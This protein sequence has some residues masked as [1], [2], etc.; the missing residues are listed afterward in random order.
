MPVSQSPRKKKRIQTK[1]HQNIGSVKIISDA[2]GEAI[3]N[4][5]EN[6]QIS[7]PQAVEGTYTLRATYPRENKGEK[8]VFEHNAG[9]HGVYLNER[10]QLCANFDRLAA[11]DTNG[12][13][14]NGE[15]VF[16]SVFAMTKTTL[17]RTE[18]DVNFDTHAFYFFG[19]PEGINKEMV[20]LDIALVNFILPELEKFPHKLGIVND[21]DLGIHREV[22]AGELPYLGDKILDPRIKLIYAS[23]DAGAQLTNEILKVCDSK[24]KKIAKYLTNNTEN[25][26]RTGVGYAYCKDL[27][28]FDLN[29]IE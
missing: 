10:A 9:A 21:S 17:S 15:E 20:G 26:E 1:K 27:V 2:N 19:V 5:D 13:I 22:N 24:A 25:I 18:P 23:T 12:V 11:I 3:F 16:I 4:I 28:I 14:I 7:S 8:V 29:K 6:G